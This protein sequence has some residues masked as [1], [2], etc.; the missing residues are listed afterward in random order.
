MTKAKAVRNRVALVT[1][2]SMGIGRAIAQALAEVGWD[3]ALSYRRTAREAEKACIFI[4][5]RG[6]RALAVRAD[7]TDVRQVQGLFRKVHKELG[8]VQ[9]LVNNVGEYTEG[10]L[11]SMSVAE[12]KATFDSN[13]H[14]AFLCT[15]EALPRMR[16]LGWGRVINITSSTA[17][18]HTPAPGA[19]AYHAAKEALLAFTRALALEEIGHGITVNAVGPGLTDNAHLGSTWEKAMT[20]LSPLGRLVEPQE[21]ARSVAFL[22]SK[23]SAAITGAHLAVGGGWDLTGGGRPD[24]SLMR[25]LS[26]R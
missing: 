9:V 2:G 12:W 25:I 1:G 17:E 11:G 4:H 3:V 19:G 18:N 14:S 7:V 26:R 8:T 24:A 16:R 23:E 10:R 21:V 13:L 22:A 20:D 15:R 6:H 5:A